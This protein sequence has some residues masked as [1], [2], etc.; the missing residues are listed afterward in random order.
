MSKNSLPPRA[1]KPAPAILSPLRPTIGVPASAG[2]QATVG[3]PGVA[4]GSAQQGSAGTPPSEAQITQA[5]HRGGQLFAAK[6]FAEAEEIARLILKFVPKQPDALHLLGLIVLAKGDAVEAEKLMTK[7]LKIMG[8]R[9][10]LFV[11]L[12]NALRA[13]QKTEKALQYYDRAEKLNP[14]LEDAHLE[15][16]I[17]LTESRRFDEALKSFETV[18]RLNPDSL[19]AYS[20]A[21]HAASEQGQF[22]LSIEYCERAEQRLGTVPVEFLAMRAVSHERLSELPEAIAV[23]ARVLAEQ[24]THGAAL[25]A[26]AKAQRRQA[27]REPE[28]LRSLKD[29]LTAIDCDSLSLD[30]ARTIYSELAQICDELGETEKAF[31]Y[32]QKQNDKTMQS[33]I[34]YDLD[35][36]SYLADLENLVSVFQPELL[37]KLEANRK[38]LIGES[39]DRV[40]TFIVGFPRS[41]TT[42]LDQILDAHPDVQVIEEQPMIRKMR[43]AID[44]LPK[45]YPNALLNLRS[46]QRKKLQAAYWREAERHGA[47]YS[48]RVIIDKMPLSLVHVPAIV[49]V[50][51]EARIILALRHPADCSL[52]CFM[53]DFEMNGAMLNFTSM[54]GTANLYDLVMT[55]WQRYEAHLTFNTRQV[56]YENL[57]TDLRGEVEPILTFLGLEWNEAVSDPAAHAKARGTIR[58]PSYAQV[59]QPIY[60]TAADRWRRYEPFIRP[61]LSRLE[62]HIRH[63]GYSL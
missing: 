56:R 6:Q 39:S 55:L 29:R 5:L 3:L 62:P 52:S 58:T 57:I 9:A 24:P 59:T 48:K 19:A 31:G 32:F 36:D 28:I 25:R 4:R 50:F 41:G 42:L 44:R 40:P 47:D 34:E 46:D 60:G 1:G 23:G 22:R 20:G 7:A 54:E 2:G 53:Q 61:A 45:A 51:P 35:R 27:K 37:D 17:L 12:G 8:P 10:L 49:S 21:A 38:N 14:A 43:Q 33:A 26:W 11:N 13:Q 18:L 15:R 30:D 16:G 63:F